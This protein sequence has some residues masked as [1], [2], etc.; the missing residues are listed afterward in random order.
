[1]Y[2]TVFTTV[3]LFRLVSPAYCNSYIPS[4]I[5]TFTKDAI[6]CAHKDRCGERLVTAIAGHETGVTT[7]MRG[8]CSAPAATHKAPSRHGAFVCLSMMLCRVVFGA[9]ENAKM[10]NG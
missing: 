1:V 8:R 7:S 4:I 5:R 2:S 6:A 10:R 9:A 3:I